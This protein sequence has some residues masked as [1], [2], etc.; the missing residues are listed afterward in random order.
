MNNTT[1][2]TKH[3]RTGNKTLNKKPGVDHNHNHNHNHNHTTQKEYCF[4]KPT[5]I[6]RKALENTAKSFG[7]LTYTEDD[8]WLTIVGEKT[9]IDNIEEVRHIILSDEYGY[10]RTLTSAVQQ[11]DIP[12]QHLKKWCDAYILGFVEGVAGHPD[13]DW[14]GTISKHPRVLGILDGTRSAKRYTEENKK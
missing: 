14:F 12:I 8:Y 9:T 5:S 4:F 11:T 2:P 10:G 6:L 1:E 3:T 13:L 7:C